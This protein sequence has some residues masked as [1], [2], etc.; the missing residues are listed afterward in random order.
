MKF[1]TL[2]ILAILALCA[3]L[4]EARPPR[5]GHGAHLYGKGRKNEGKDV[6]ATYTAYLDDECKIEVISTPYETGD[7]FAPVLNHA[8]RVGKVGED[9]KLDIYYRYGSCGREFKSDVMRFENG[10]CKKDKLTGIYV[11][12]TWEDDN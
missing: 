10:V 12:W 1:T 6:D 11:K 7:C 8:E 5:F 9:K 4:S 3:V 2:V